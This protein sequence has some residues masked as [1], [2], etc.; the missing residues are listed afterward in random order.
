MTPAPQLRPYQRDAL[1]AVSSGLAGGSNRLL[2]KKP[3][4]TGKTVMFAAILEQ[5]RDWLAQFPEQ[6]RKMLVIAHREELLDQAAEKIR[7]ANPGLMVMV[8]QGDRRASVYADVIIASIQTLAAMRFR[9]LKRFL[10]RTTFRVVVVDEAHH[11]AAPTYRTALA[12]LGFLPMADAS[13]T[14]DEEAA[15]HDDVEAMT[16]ALSGWDQVAPKDRLLLGVTATPNRSDAIGLGCVF[17]SIAYAYNLKDAIADGWLV[18]IT[19]WAIETSTSLDEVRLAR[20][21][22]NQ[23]ELAEA[24]NNQ[25]RN[26]LAVAAWREHAQGIPTIAFT[27]DVAH[28]H[29]LAEAFTL[30]GFRARAV[31]GVTPKDERRDM[32]AAFQD[33]R[34][35][36]LANCMVL[37]EGT[38]LPRA[39][40]I[41]H[42]K[43]TKSATLYE[44]MT[45]R[46]LRLFPG[47]R[48][49]V[50]IDL[51]DVA[52]RHS[53]QAAPVLYGLPPGIISK[54]QKLEA[55]AADLEQ[56]LE[57]HAGLDLEK[58]LAG[59]PMTLEQL[60]AHA[61]TFDI[62]TVPSL[63]AFGNGRALN[64]I[65]V[66]EDCYRLQYP[67]A[68]G[69][70]TLEVSRD[71]IDKWNLSLTLRPK[72]D[73]GVRQR[74]IAA[75]IITADEAAGLAEAFILQERRSVMSLRGKDAPWR[76]R[77]ASKKQLDMLK[78]MRVPPQSIPRACTMGQASDLIDLA[79][80]RRR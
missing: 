29:A 64:W 23:R 24:V 10:E 78:K 8:E 43:P 50:V 21:D 15:T 33:G 13:E 41:L 59:H 68:D 26:Q 37:T 62:W 39:G 18:P 52:R 46:G 19:P 25:K 56:L 38:D 45:G 20:G 76:S 2:I 3:T 80:A 11:A 6:H 1:A 66:G 31:S 30:A 34:L 16:A 58:A 22:F 69:H 27:V 35:D 17:Q 4:G 73:G 55:V 32:L 61:A 71:L 75:Q 28:A 9:R 65:K 42:A 12:H 77:P 47:K 74:T 63:G 72:G 51:V 79:R 49:C 57:K 40:C 14:E 7:A 70:E 44:Q 5:L 53:L 60:R 54:G 36:V 48:D 67:W